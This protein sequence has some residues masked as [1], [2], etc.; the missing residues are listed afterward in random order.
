MKKL[1]GFCGLDCEQCDAYRAT[2]ND[3]Q[4]LREKTARLWAEQNQAP[5]LP[6]HINCLGCRGEGVKTV[7]CESMCEIRQC[8]LGRGA[9]TCGDCP[10]LAE[11]GKVGEVL[12][13]SPEALANLRNL[14]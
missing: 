9:A 1:I 2:V 7:F 5:I 11:C 8:G 13:N 10:E 6:E 4:A 14:E 3:D 12:R